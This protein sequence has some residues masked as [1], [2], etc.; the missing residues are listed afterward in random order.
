MPLAAAVNRDAA[1]AK[2]DGPG[3]P[4]RRS[5]QRSTAEQCGALSLELKPRFNAVVLG[6]VNV[7]GLPACAARNSGQEARPALGAVAICVAPLPLA[8]APKSKAEVCG[9]PMIASVRRLCA[10]ILPGHP[11]G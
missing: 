11:H 3:F 2:N 8:G 7:E 1:E 5:T 10:C 6:T 9:W 4:K